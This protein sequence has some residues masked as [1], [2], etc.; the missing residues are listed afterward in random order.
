MFSPELHRLSELELQICTYQ[1]CACQA[2]WLEEYLDLGL[3]IASNKPEPWQEGWMQRLF[4]TI[5]RA[6]N[7]PA[8]SMAWRNQC[9]DYL[10]QPFFVLV[11]MYRQHPQKSCHLCELLKQYAQYEKALSR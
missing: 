8:A 4:N 9:V 3:N 6:V 11:Q 7:N 5:C 2:T 1:G 10:Y